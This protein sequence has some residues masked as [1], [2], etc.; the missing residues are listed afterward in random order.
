MSCPTSALV[1]GNFHNMPPSCALKAL[2][3]WDLPSRVRF[4][5]F[6]REMLLKY[7]MDA[8]QFITFVLVFAG[9]QTDD[10][11]QRISDTGKLA[12]AQK[13]LQLMGM[14][15]LMTIG[16][17]HTDEAWLAAMSELTS[18]LGSGLYAPP[19]MASASSSDSGMSAPM[20]NL[21]EA[22]GPEFLLQQSTW[23]SAAST[24]EHPGGNMLADF[25]LGQSEDMP[26][27]LFNLLTSTLV[28]ADALPPQALP[29]YGFSAQEPG[30]DQ[31]DYQQNPS[32]EQ[33]EWKGAWR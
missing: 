23:H 2:G 6:M 4:Q 10:V 27:D 16:A 21:A 32:E 33:G 14:M 30:A 18:S 29:A 7:P 20:L 1:T 5:N 26:A 8:N 12:A 13:I 11:A 3:V 24:H 15:D 9:G 17:D 31:S 22:S 25:S 28:Q 19:D